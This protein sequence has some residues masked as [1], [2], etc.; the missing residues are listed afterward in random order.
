MEH[1]L[2]VRAFTVRY[3]Q[4][5]AAEFLVPRATFEAAMRRRS[6]CAAGQRVR[7]LFVEDGRC[8]RYPGHRRPRRRLC[9]RL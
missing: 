2:V 9:R 8:E 6:L 3:R 1:P 7:M 4:S 5:D